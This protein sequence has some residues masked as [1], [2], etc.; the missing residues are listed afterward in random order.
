MSVTAAPLRI[1]IFAKAPVA[2]YAKTRLIPALGE[3]GAAQL[4][5][6]LLLHTVREALA[7]N[8]GPVELCVAPDMQQTLWST[9]SLPIE[10]SWSE[11]GEGALGERMARAA[12][13]VIDGGENLLIIGTDCPQ[14]MAE[15][16][17][18]AAQ[19]LALHDAC[20]V[21]A[22][23][24]GY[25]LLGLRHYH[26]S[27]FTDI[28]WSTADV[29]SLT[30]QRIAALGWTLREFDS[31]HDIDEPADLCWLPALFNSNGCIK[32]PA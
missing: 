24:G 7:A 13:R 16:L 29:A 28:P 31:L 20:L 23:D 22:F 14:L 26:A 9:L 8:I 2:G 6:Q 25:V 18:S 30:R 1:V 17:R 11:Q 15:D 3:D 21:P 27:L 10:L 5:R 32:G 19:A 12:K 4:A